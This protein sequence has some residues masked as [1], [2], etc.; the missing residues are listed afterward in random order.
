[1]TASSLPRRSVPNR[2]WLFG[3][4]GKVWLGNDVDGDR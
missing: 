3:Q 4:P 2:Q 1:M